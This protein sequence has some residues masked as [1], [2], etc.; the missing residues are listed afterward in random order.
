MLKLFILITKEI[1][2]SAC[3]LNV[4]VSSENKKNPA[5]SMADFCFTPMRYLFQGRNV[6]I[7][8]HKVINDEPAFRLPTVPGAVAAILLLVPGIIFGLI[9]KFF[10]IFSANTRENDKV[11]LEYLK[12]KNPQDISYHSILSKIDTPQKVQ[13]YYENAPEGVKENGGFSTGEDYLSSEDVA[14]LAN[15]YVERHKESPGYDV[16]NVKLIEDDKSFSNLKSYLNQLLPTLKE[17]ENAKIIS[18][19]RPTLCH[20]GVHC[21]FIYLRKEDGKIKLLTLDPGGGIKYDRR[22]SYDKSIPTCLEVAKKHNLEI[23]IIKQS[24]LVQSDTRNCPIYALKAMKYFAKHGHT[25]FRNIQENDL[26]PQKSQICDKEYPQVRHL[27]VGKLPSRL[28]KMTNKRSSDSINRGYLNIDKK[29]LTPDYFA[30]QEKPYFKNQLDDVVSYK[31]FENGDKQPVTLKEYL[32]QNQKFVKRDD[33]TIPW[34]FAAI[35][36]M[37]KYRK[38]IAETYR[39]KGILD[40]DNNLIS[41]AAINAHVQDLS[42]ILIT[43]PGAA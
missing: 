24:A 1:K 28:L 12:N 21:S 34:N 36:H 16:T 13:K 43:S 14:S 27:K 9:A 30:S 23:S 32:D 8:N 6:K 5:D 35:D 37:N 17:G 7:L 4:K 10:S 41:R 22:M 2:M 33:A 18:K 38:R 42:R 19:L 26:V 15:E 25:F 29:V 20:W 39:A 40:K 31:H 11:A 3:A